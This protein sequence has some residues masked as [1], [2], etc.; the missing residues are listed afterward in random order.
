[1]REKI[2]KEGHRD[3]KERNDGKRWTVRK[4]SKRAM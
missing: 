2:R 1:M 3:W 4:K